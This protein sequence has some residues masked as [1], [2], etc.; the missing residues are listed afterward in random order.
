MF[1]SSQS[2]CAHAESVS[3]RK[4][5]ANRANSLKSTGPRSAAGKQRASRNAI[6][7]GIFSQQSVLPGESQAT[8]DALRRELIRD[9]RPQNVT[10]LFL[11]EQMVQSMWRLN[12]LRAAETACHEAHTDTARRQLSRSEAAR[13]T[14]P[15]NMADMLGSAPGDSSVLEKLHRY[16]KRLEGTFHRSLKELRRLRTTVKGEAI[17]DQPSPFL[18]E[19]EP[20]T[21]AES[22]VATDDQKVQNE[23][24]AATAPEETSLVTRASLPAPAILTHQEPEFSDLSRCAHGRNVRV[25]GGEEHDTE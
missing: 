13:L 23:A 17:P 24:T 6:A 1:R 19:D 9:H 2:S 12:R 14:T 7:H 15:G 11:V 18:E 4:A 16:E 20:E 5:R 3:N 10:E 21:P 25:T 22:S 8:F